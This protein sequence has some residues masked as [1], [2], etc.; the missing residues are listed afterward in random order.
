MGVER[1]SS[2]TNLKQTEQK[3]DSAMEILKWA[4][5]IVQVVGIGMSGVMRLKG[6]PKLV[7]AVERP[8]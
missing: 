7:E 3:V 1:E 5:A 4:T 6:S 8:G 2:I